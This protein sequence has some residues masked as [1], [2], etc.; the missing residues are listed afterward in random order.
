[1]KYKDLHKGSFQ[2]K[3]GHVVNNVDGRSAGT[4]QVALADSNDIVDV[5]Y[6]SPVKY[7]SGG[8]IAI[9]KET[10][11]VVIIKPANADDWIYLSTVVDSEQELE[12]KIIKET[13]LTDHIPYFGQTDPYSHT[14]S[15]DSIG[16]YNR[17]G[18]GVEISSKRNESDDERFVSVKGAT[19]HRMIIADN[20]QNDSIGLYN[21]NGFDKLKLT[22]DQYE[23]LM[24]PE[25]AELNVTRNIDLLSLEGSI[26]VCLDGGRR[27]DIYNRSRKD[28]MKDS[29]EDN[30]CGQINMESYHNDIVIKVNAEDSRILLVADGPDSIIQ[31]RT[32]GSVN[33]NAEKDINLQSGQNINIAAAGDVNIEGAKINLNPGPPGT[34]AV[35]SP[36]LTNDEERALSNG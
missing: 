35:P 28:V 22:G 10:D 27:I 31:L 1:M 14:I 33:V 11:L 17:D 26:H 36:E 6:S 32:N 12:N 8:L 34:V 18:N 3:V 20:G 24:G 2:A 15:P 9:P 30:A 23:G 29:D 13:P 5:K 19:D 4:F 25:S 7:S 16:L 21:N